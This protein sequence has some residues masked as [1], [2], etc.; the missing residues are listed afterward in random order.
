MEVLTDKKI[1]TNLN[2]NG[3]QSA[4]T[5]KITEYGDGVQHVTKIK[6]E[7][8][9][10]GPLAG[11]AAALLLV[12]PTALYT[13]PAGS[14]VLEV[15]HM[16]LGLSC[17]GTAVTPE[18]GLGSVVGDGSAAAALSGTFEDIHQGYAIADTVTGAEVENGPVGVTAGIL[19]GIA[20]N[21]SSD[22]KTIYL[23]CAGTWNADNVG[24]LLANGEITIVWKTT[25]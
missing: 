18:A 16:N 3:K 6:L 9:V 5:L 25:S 11:A 24:N 19:T 4:G 8:Y 10:V 17:A 13:L 1:L 7:N 15:S 12:P 2:N 22:A 20:L 23:N 14:Q 21:K